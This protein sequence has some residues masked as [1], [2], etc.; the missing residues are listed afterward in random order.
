MNNN[1]I[2]LASVI[3]PTFMVGLAVGWAAGLL[4][5]ALMAS[6]TGSRRQ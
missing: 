4:R 3:I 2:Q 1:L 5:A 6:S